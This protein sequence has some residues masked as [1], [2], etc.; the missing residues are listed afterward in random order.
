MYFWVLS[1]ILGDNMVVDAAP[2][3]AVSGKSGTININWSGAAEYEWHIGAIFHTRNGILQG[4]TIL[5]V[6]NRVLPELA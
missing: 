2:A 4:S 3:S 6:Y 1:K 5:N